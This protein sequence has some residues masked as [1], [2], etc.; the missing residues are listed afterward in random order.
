MAI[1]LTVKGHGDPQSIGRKVLC[2][3]VRSSHAALGAPLENAAMLFRHVAMI[4][5]SSRAS[6]TP[7]IL[8]DVNFTNRTVTAFNQL[9]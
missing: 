2:R 7:F 8:F 4:T 9:L 1:R 3:C 6:N 5:K